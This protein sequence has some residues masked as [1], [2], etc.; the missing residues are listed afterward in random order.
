MRNAFGEEY[1]QSERVTKAEKDSTKVVATV[2][3]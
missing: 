2:D 3:A 1:H